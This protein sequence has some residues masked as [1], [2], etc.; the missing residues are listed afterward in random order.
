LT[1]SKKSPC[2]ESIVQIRILCG[3][4]EET[5]VR[6]SFFP[7]IALAVF[8]LF[9]LLACGGGN[10]ESPPPTTTRPWTQQLGTPYNDTGYGVGAFFAAIANNIFVGASLPPTARFTLT[11]MV[12]ILSLATIFLALVQSAI[13]LYI[14]DTVGREKLHRYFDKVSFTVFLIGYTATNLLLPL[15]AKS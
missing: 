11:A 8:L 7:L 15:A 12:N 9:L 4:E 13:S 3:E 1:N 5:G 2:H 10:E 14:E 6:R